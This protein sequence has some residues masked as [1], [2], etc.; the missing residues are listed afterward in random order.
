MPVLVDLSQ[1]L[2]DF[3]SLM[4][5]VIL[6]VVELHLA[7]NLLPQTEFDLA[8]STGWS[9]ALDCLL[10]LSLSLIFRGDLVLEG[11]QVSQA[12]EA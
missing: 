4:P 3:Q 9:L 8:T 1:V 7:F 12:W 2:V 11:W 5:V 6:W 10:S